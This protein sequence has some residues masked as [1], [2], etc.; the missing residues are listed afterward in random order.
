[1]PPLCF[2]NISVKIRRMFNYFTFLSPTVERPCMNL[3]LLIT[4]PHHLISLFLAYPT[5]WMSECLCV[6]PDCCSPELISGESLMMP[7]WPAHGMLGLGRCLEDHLEPT[8]I[9]RRPG[10]GSGVMI[11]SLSIKKLVPLLD[12]NPGAL[13]PIAEISLPQCLSPLL[14]LLNSFY[15]IPFSGISLWVL[16]C[17][18]SLVLFLSFHL[19]FCFFPSFSLFLLRGA[20]LKCSPWALFPLSTLPELVRLF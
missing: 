16:G 11:Y 19:F 10:P 2:L 4:S 9:Q 8:T 20:W 14:F 12:W 1:M 17:Y 15:S 18:L 13:I 5:S 3:A 7:W 6:L